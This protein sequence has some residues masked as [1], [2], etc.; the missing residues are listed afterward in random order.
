MHQ[1]GSLYGI[2]LLRVAEIAAETDIPNKTR[3]AVNEAVNVI[4]P[5][6]VKKLE[7]WNAVASR[8]PPRL[9]DVKKPREFWLTYSSEG[10]AVTEETVCS[11]A[12]I[13]TSGSISWHCGTD[14][15]TK[16]SEVP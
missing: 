5:R 9:P 13:A 4:N 14:H 6:G 7:Q 10:S 2:H 1:S 3:A 11:N 12:G 15:T 16:P 8:R